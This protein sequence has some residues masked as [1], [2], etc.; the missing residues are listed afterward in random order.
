[1]TKKCKACQA[2]ISGLLA[3]VSA[4]AGVKQSTKY[5]DYCNKCEGMLDKKKGE[6]EEVEVKEPEVTN[7]EIEAATDPTVAPPKEE[8]PKSE[9]KPGSQEEKEEDWAEEL[10]KK[11]EG[12]IAQE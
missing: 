6:S 11:H 1:M 3:K 9:P 12:N 8:K 2:P 10:K 7:Q 4:F 5:P